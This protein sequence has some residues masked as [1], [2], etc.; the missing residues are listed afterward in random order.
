MPRQQPNQSL[1]GHTIQSAESTTPISY[2]VMEWLRS[3]SVLDTYLAVHSAVA[4][5]IEL[6]VFAT[7]LTAQA[8]FASRF[9]SQL[10]VLVAL[11][12]PSLAKVYD[13]GRDGGYFF[14][15][16]EH[17][18]SPTLRVKLDTDGKLPLPIA[19]NHARL[20]ADT[21]GYAAAQNV[22]HGLLSPNAVTLSSRRGPV[23]DH[24]GLIP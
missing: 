13:Y 11:N 4:L 8:D 3:T 12:V 10:K 2:K 9:V 18:K 23:L 20:I 19:L 22:L 14:I 7:L 5:K 1:V 17:H 16:I 15:A 24:F 21:L 6:Q